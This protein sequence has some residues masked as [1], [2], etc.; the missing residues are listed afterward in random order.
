[1]NSAA[2]DDIRSYI[3][4]LRVSLGNGRPAVSRKELHSFFKANDYTGMVKFI[5]DS[6]NLDVRL[7][8]GIANRGG[9]PNAMAWIPLPP[10]LPPFGSREFREQKFTVFIKKSFLEEDRFEQVVMAIGLIDPRRARSA[11]RRSARPALYPPA[12]PINILLT[13]SGHYWNV[14]SGQSVRAL[15]AVTASSR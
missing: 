6:M 14:H 1:M 12:R 5:R 11:T 10:R 9:P 13:I 4:Q 7:R 15:E 3:A 8:L 2:L